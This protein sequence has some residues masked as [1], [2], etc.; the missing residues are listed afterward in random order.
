MT[1][2]MIARCPLPA[3]LPRDAR[4]EAECA[5]PAADP[6]A[7]VLALVDRGDT[8]AAVVRLMERYGR[9]VYRYCREALRD[10]TLA[11][12]VHQQVFIAVL[13]DLAQFK[14]RAAVRIWLFAIA[15][16]RVLDAGKKL[17]TD[18]AWADASAAADTPD[19]GPSAAESL[20]DAR[21]RH[22]LAASLEAL[23]PEVR[24]AVLLR[25]QQGFTFSEMAAVCGEQA[26][27]LCA[28]VS[29]ALPVLRR[30]IKAQ[31]GDR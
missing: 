20:D 3:A 6:D 21:L 14:R 18:R 11:D 9:A 12:D 13:R 16:H 5:R 19:P 30:H 7:D 27:T 10:A 28:R 22:A 29:R 15:R 4:R 2:A 25:Y 8:T 23:S 1:H 24:T 26:G 17:R 31:L